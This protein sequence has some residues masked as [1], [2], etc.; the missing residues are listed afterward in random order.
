[1]YKVNPACV[2]QVLIIFCFCPSHVLGEEIDNLVKTGK[3]IINDYANHLQKDYGNAFHQKNSVISDIC[4][5]NV[6]PPVING[7]QIR[8]ISLSTLNKINAPDAIDTRIL[9]DF[10]LKLA[11]G[12]GLERLAYYKLDETE[13]FK[14]FRYYKAFQYEQRCLSCH[15]NKEGNK[16]LTPGLGAYVIVKI[17]DQPVPGQLQENKKFTLPAYK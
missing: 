8:R 17:I 11:E 6:Q 13:N 10:N 7:W 1:M 12:W 3:A 4:K 16:L 5:K 9:E 14:Q 15:V 2:W